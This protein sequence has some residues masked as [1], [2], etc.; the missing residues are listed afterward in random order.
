MRLG[1]TVGVQLEIVGALDRADQGGDAPQR[2]VVVQAL[3]LLEEGGDLA[4]KLGDGRSAVVGRSA[5]GRFEL[6]LEQ[7]Q[8]GAGHV[9]I[10]AQRLFLHGL[11][12][13][14]AGLLAI[15][16]QGADQGRLAPFDAQF[17]HQTI[18]AV[19]LVAAGPDGGE[20]VLERPLHI[21]EDQ[22]LAARILHQELMDV[23]LGVA[24]R[25]DGVAIFLQ[26][27]QAHVGQ[28]RQN[29]GQGHGRAATIQF[30]AE[31]QAAVVRVAEGAHGDGLPLPRRAGVVQPGHELQVHRRLVGVV[32]VAVARAEG[33][34]PF[35][36]DRPDRNLFHPRTAQ[37]RL[38]AIDPTATR[39][40]HVGLQLDRIGD[41]V[42]AGRH[43]DD[44]V[45]AHQGR[46]GQLRIPGRDT[47]A[48][49]AG[50]DLADALAHRRVELLARDEAQHRNE[51]VERILA[52]EQAN[53]R[54]VIQMQYAQ[55]DGQ[56]FVLADL[57]KLVARIV[58]QNVLQAF[59]VVAA[60]RLVRAGQ[61]VGHLAA[62]QRHLGRQLVVGL[63]REQ[64][65]EAG[66][67]RR[68]AVRAVTLDPD[69]VHVSPAMHARAGVGLGHRD[70]LRQIQL[71]AHLVRQDRG[72]G[73]AAQHGALGV[74]QYAKA[75]AGLAERRLGLVV[76]VGGARIVVVA[77]AQEDEMVALQPF[78]EGDVLVP[79]RL[80]D[81]R[82]R[83]GL[84]TLDRLAHQAR[85]GLVVGDGGVDV[86]QALGQ[87]L[88][89]DVATLLRHAVDD[90]HDDRQATTVQIDHRVEQGAHR[91]GG[92]GQGAH[93][94]VDQEG[95]VRLDDA[96]QV[97]VQRLAVHPMHRTDSDG[98]GRRFGA[99]G[100]GR[101]PGRGQQ[102]GQVL[103]A[104]FGR[105]VSGVILVRLGQIDLLRRAGPGSDDPGEGR[106]QRGLGDRLD[107]GLAQIGG[108][109]GRAVSNNAAGPL[110]KRRDV[111]PQLLT[112][113]GPV[114]RE[115]PGDRSL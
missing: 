80:I 39:L 72:L 6:G 36:A 81:G 87:A 79:H 27:L 40:G 17:D 11:G 97:I 18:E 71:A 73:R 42:I 3:H 32:A 35:G 74:R 38:E 2:A 62:Q 29:V 54:P 103:A 93:D 77:R 86:G 111:A 20:G 109:H 47:A 58:L 49:G 105:L 68:L 99:I 28:D 21:V 55:G 112:R 4:F 100:P 12:R 70:R 8:Q 15:V 95:G 82:G 53:A 88:A 1:L 76:A 92:L 75:L 51:A 10:L 89:Q 102:G 67:A 43:A 34:R 5:D 98:R 50:D 57:E 19:A 110:E 9:G 64:A 115:A 91:D 24:Q 106:L 59:F 13:I 113:P 14:E 66:F 33:P 16:G 46:V 44:V 48:P 26:R 31:L 90:Q 94:A 107:D 23:D 45:N 85:H 30:E 83:G 60:R 56:Q 37:A 41:R 114:A 101:R 65:D 63:G 22:G 52:R 61:G 78:Q 84:Q 108:G 104:Q 69:V 25:T 96:D 7:R